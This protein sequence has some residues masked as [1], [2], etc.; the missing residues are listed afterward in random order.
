MPELLS[1]DRTDRPYPQRITRLPRHLHEV[2]A[3]WLTE[4]LQ[5]R[6]PNVVVKGAE[7]IEVLSTHT[8]KLRLRLD[9]N[10]AGR[11]AGIP[12]FVCLKS[13]WSDGIKTGDLCEQ[14]ARFFHLMQAANGRN[15]TVPIPQAFFADWDG[16]GGGR[17]VVMMEDL[18]SPESSGGTNS[19]GRFGNSADHLGVDGVAAGLESMA[20]LHASMWGPR[21]EREAWMYRSMTTPIDT[22]QV[23]RIYNYMAL[24]LED[25]AY[26]AVLPS[27]AYETPARLNHLLDELSAYELEQ[28]G[29]LSLV[30]G[31]A[32]QGNTYVARNGQRLWLDFQLVRKGTPFRDVNYFMIGALTIDERRGHDRELLKLYLECLR[33]NGAVGVLSLDDAW[34]QFRRWSAY[35]MQCW[36]G[37]VDLWGQAGIEMIRRFYASGDDYDTVNLLLGGKQ[38]RRNV[39]LG[40]GASPLPANL[41]AIRDSRSGN[42]A[43]T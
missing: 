23:I 9:L 30:H 29:P 5:L 4:M 21:V 32:H 42:S 34:E 35:G 14:E 15:K 13:N 24:N 37:N 39:V 3:A 12:E 40:E 38:P 20:M 18:A 33:A 2:T 16:D 19:G 6:Y 41:Q 10:D 7:T 8:T 11:S 25:P 1:A 28:S 17:G 31:D 36:L 26:Q 43:V 22:D 27:W